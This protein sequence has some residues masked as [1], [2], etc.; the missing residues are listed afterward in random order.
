MSR[1]RQSQS[2]APEAVVLPLHR[3]R[4]RR[5]TRELLDG[6]LWAELLPLL[7]EHWLEV[8][9][10]QDIPLRPNVTAYAAL[11][12]AGILRVFTARD[13]AGK[14]YGYGVFLVIPD[15]NY[16]T[17]LQATMSVL[18]IDPQARGLASI[19]FIA[20]CDEQLANEGV[21]VINQ[22]VKA[23]HNFGKILERLGYKLINL[24][25]SKK[26]Y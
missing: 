6:K 25:Y 18:Y 23:E 1:T 22:H 3:A 4:D 11:E 7:R 12:A 9:P 17:S 13:G 2:P 26:L 19:K 5:F 24:S 15:L 21:Q 20:W 10:F 16:S 14:L 8:A